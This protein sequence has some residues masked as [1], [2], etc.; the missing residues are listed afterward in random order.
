M[1]KPLLVDVQRTA[2]MVTHLQLLPVALHQSGWMGSGDDGELG[3][4]VRGSRSGQGPGSLSAFPASSD[5]FYLHLQPSFFCFRS[6]AF[7]ASNV[8]FFLHWN[9]SI[10][11]I[12]FRLLASGYH[13]RI[14]EAKLRACLAASTVLLDEWQVEPALWNQVLRAVDAVDATGQFMLTGSDHPYLDIV[15]S[16]TKAHPG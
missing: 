11:C 8:Q 15:F 5:R 4:T 12:A 13:P 16:S 3:R 2:G 10:R 14:A 1:L 7:P 9:S 6:P